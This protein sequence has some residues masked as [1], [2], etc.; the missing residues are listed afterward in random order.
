[1][2]TSRPIQLIWT[3]ID[4]TSAACS[5]VKLVCFAYL[6]GLLQVVPIG[7]DADICITVEES[8]DGVNWCPYSGC[9]EDIVVSGVTNVKTSQVYGTHYRVCIDPKT[10]TTGTIDIN[11]NLK[12]Q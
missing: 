2:A 9:A 10:N 5:E 7:L 6:G 12:Q 3:G 8:N 4:A 11:W 1:M